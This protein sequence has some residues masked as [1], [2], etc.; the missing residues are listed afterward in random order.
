MLDPAHD[1][2]NLPFQLGFVSRRLGRSF[3]GT[4]NCFSH[5]GRRTCWRRRSRT[6]SAE[7]TRNRCMDDFQVTWLADFGSRDMHLIRHAQGF[8]EGFVM[9]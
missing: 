1:T 2:G 8:E 9:G 6:T 7:V 4:W 5:M 3:G